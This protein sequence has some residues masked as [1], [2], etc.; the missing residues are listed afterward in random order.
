M[1]TEFNLYSMQKKGM[2]DGVKALVGVVV[3]L[4]LIAYL[5]PTALSGLF[6]TTAF[7]YVNG[8]LSV[9]SGVPLWVPT[10]L[11]II[12]VVGIIYVIL[13]AIDR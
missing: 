3:L 8:N 12:G 7:S 2:A 11:G 5:A 4:L 6:N 1:E 13:D 9:S 10:V